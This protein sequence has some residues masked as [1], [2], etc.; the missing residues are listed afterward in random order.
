M[1]LARNLKKQIS[2]QQLISYYKK[3]KNWSK[4]ECEIKGLQGDTLHEAEEKKK[5][6]I[7][8][9]HKIVRIQ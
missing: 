1:S 6:P 5:N 8:V 9:I 2:R 4:L 3:K 7:N